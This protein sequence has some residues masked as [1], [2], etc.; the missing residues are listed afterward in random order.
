MKKHTKYSALILILISCINSFSQELLD[1]SYFKCQ[2]DYSRYLKTDFKET[3]ED[4][5]IVQ[6]GRK[7]TKCY[8]Y[9]TA[10][11]DSIFE[12]PNSREI[13][14]QMFSKALKEAKG[15]P[16]KNFP[17]RRSKEFIYKNYSENEMTVVDG[18][19]A[20]DYIYND[21]LFVQKWQ[22]LNDTTTILGYLCQKAICSFR[23]RDYTAWF[24]ES[25]PISEGPWKFMGLPGLIVKV[26][27]T[28]NIFT[29]TLTGAEQTKEAIFFSK[30][31]SPSGK[32]IKTK[33]EK[34][35]ALNNKF[36]NNIETY[37]KAESGLDIFPDKP[38]SKSII[39]LLEL[40]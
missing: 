17:Y 25:I 12:L 16:A 18:I 33:R 11:C 14:S 15:E 22:I 1:S 34:F 23:G 38:K 13:W 7:V 26:Y 27:D 36:L 9:Y 19:S 24:T 29:F 8:S 6:I 21:S 28:D 37:T 35:L 40:K 2:Y 30:S 5:L 10:Q 20:D 3:R 39:N 32:F 31:T 4:V